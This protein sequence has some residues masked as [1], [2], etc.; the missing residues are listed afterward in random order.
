MQKCPECNSG[1]EN[2]FSYC[3]YCGTNLIDKE[4]ELEQ[5][6]MLGK[7]DFTDEELLRSNMSQ[8]N[9]GVLDKVFASLMSNL[10]N[11]MNQ[12]IQDTAEVKSYPG[13]VRIK[14]GNVSP[15]AKRNQVEQQ[16]TSRKA[17]TAEQARKMSEFPRVKAKTAMRRLGDKI[18]YELSAPGVS[19]PNDIFLAKLESG[20]EI[21]AI[22]GNKIYI[23]SLPI[24]LPLRGVKLQPD[25]V[26]IEFMTNDEEN[27]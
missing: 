24:N 25:K 17:L 1:I 10:I 27:F 14:I 7:D 18:I 12:Q 22:G 15:K 20:Y 21:K 8:T 5:F 13:G 11:T 3:P 9:L 2:K 23:N 16:K 26:L 19:S 4:E 6:G